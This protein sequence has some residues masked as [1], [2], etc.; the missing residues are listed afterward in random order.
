MVV[1]L[2]AP[3]YRSKQ[4]KG[5]GWRRGWFGFG[6]AA[7]HPTILAVAGGGNGPD[8]VSTRSCPRGTTL[9]GAGAMVAVRSLWHAVRTRRALSGVRDVRGRRKAQ[10][11]RGS[12]RPGRS[13]GGGPGGTGRHWAG[14]DVALP[15]AAP[16][17]GRQRRQ[18]GRGQHPVTSRT[19]AG[20]QAGNPQ[21]VSEGRES[22][23]DRI[24][25]GPAGLR[26][27]FSGQTT[28]QAGCGRVVVGQRRRGCGRPGSTG[29]DAVCHVHHPAV[30]AGH[31]DPDG[32][33]RHVSD[34]RADCERPLEA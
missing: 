34:R 22:Q 12:L 4:H 31:E 10:Q 26:R 15:S 27:G 1:A 17:P 33:V 2:D 21:S 14:F 28:G 30:P 23:P 25:Q 11:S 20:R 32:R 13:D 18:P 19:E 6:N 5:F 7:V 29:R 16:R 8:P 3:L 9:D 24:V